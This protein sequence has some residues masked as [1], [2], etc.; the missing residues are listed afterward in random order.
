MW[1]GVLLA[2]AQVSLTQSAYSQETPPT[3]RPDVVDTGIKPDAFY[4]LDEFGNRV[5]LPGLTFEEIDRL[6]KS[7]SGYA[8]N[9]TPY[10][11]EGISITGSARE[12]EAELA[13]TVKIN[14]A[15][16]PGEYVAIP[17]SMSTFHLRGP[18]DVT[19]VEE[20][21]MKWLEEGGSLLWVRAD[22]PRKVEVIMRVVTRVGNDSGAGIEFRLPLAPTNIS[23]NV[24]GEGL[25]ANV[26]GRGDEIVRTSSGEP[27]NT[28]VEIEC[29]GG[30]FSLQWQKRDTALP[31]DQVLE[32]N[33]RHRVLWEDPQAPPAIAVE[34]EVQNRR[35]NIGPFEISL[36]MGAEILEPLQNNVSVQLAT[37]DAG[38]G[39]IL[40]TPNAAE[41][42][43]RVKFLIEY[44]LPAG[45]YTSD[46]P[47]KVLPI[48]VSNA[49]RHSGEVDVRINRNFR[50]R[51]LQS[52]SV[53]SAWR[54][55]TADP[56][57]QRVYL[58]QFDRV[59]FELPLWLIAKQ[60]RLRIEPEYTFR[61]DKQ[62]VVLEAMISATGTA[63][64]G[65]PLLLDAP[66]WNISS[67]VDQVSGLRLD[68]ALSEDGQG[69]EL[70]LAELA[71]NANSTV[72]VRWNATL[73]EPAE[74]QQVQF[75]IPQIRSV[76]DRSILVVPAIL[77]L[78]ADDDLS[79]IADLEKST[80]L[81]PQ[82]ADPSSLNNS[83]LN[84][85][86]RVQ[87]F[88]LQPTDGLPV[89]EGY[90]V[91]KPVEASIEATVSA[92]LIADD[93]QVVQD[94]S[95]VPSGNLKGQL[96]LRN[97]V[98]AFSLQHNGVT[99]SVPVIWQIYVNDQL[100]LLRW[101]GED[102]A[103]LYADM[104]ASL[105]CRIRMVATLS[106]PKA[107][108]SEFENPEELIVDVRTPRSDLPGVRVVG[109]VPLS[110]SSST[111]FD[112]SLVLDGGTS[113][114]S[115]DA[116]AFD[117]S[118]IRIHQRQQD[119][120]SRLVVERALLRSEIGRSR[121]YDRLLCRVVGG[122]NNFFV[123][124]HD[125]VFK[126]GV[127]DL[128]VRVYIDGVEANSFTI[129]NTRLSI[130]LSEA[131][132]SRLVDIRMWQSRQGG[133]IADFIEPAMQLPI[134]TGKTF[135]DVVLPTDRHLIW[136]SSG[137]NELMLWRYS[138]LFVQ[139]VA[140]RTHAELLEWI[141]GPPPP[142]SQGGNRYL[143]VSSDPSSLMFMEAGKPILWLLVSSIVLTIST[144]L[145][146]VPR[147]RHPL[148]A[149]AAATLVAGMAW[150]V[151]DV[152][153]IS[154][155]LFIGAFIVVAVMFG[156]RA[157]LVRRP[158]ATVM[159]GTGEISSVHSGTGRRNLSPAEPTSTRLHEAVTGSSA[160]GAPP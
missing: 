104:L 83:T 54:A 160:V 56:L 87:K 93:L 113:S 78:T 153:V 117:S 121:R 155:Q 106:L 13:V 29:T 89:F 1:L 85:G 101:T 97:V 27:G 90:L 49:V 102:H 107:A 139:R 154:G 130:P 40:V 149:V 144:L 19:G 2:A 100:G 22:Q 47:L 105:P 50:L 51:W 159:G 35:G 123:S 138:Q 41:P 95:V 38:A 115:K 18:A 96:P 131:K 118:S 28:K 26:L 46:S 140:T 82:P 70:V 61:V 79:V 3:N 44:R 145:F 135:W 4:F 111:E 30:D 42:T 53:R 152:A 8:P 141:G 64:E 21:G 122:D 9:A 25:S 158:R 66:G 136:S 63:L 74:N 91:D 33:S 10:T 110:L 142:E 16:T 12:T 39:K 125:S 84:S 45:D 37:R 94:W 7:D 23:I 36:P 109:A 150:L 86:S 52:P 103:T 34:M 24:A 58:F 5:M 31:S 127:S 108:V 15:A 98:Q 11:F 157:I 151:P 43:G 72:I 116:Y 137:S 129:Q 81:T 134:S 133:M 156:V 120:S 128:A 88:R 75:R 92:S 73:A 69:L 143:L 60:Q 55:S 14:V 20:S 17:L 99:I 126:N 80:G 32:V 124:L 59:P 119:N 57:D 71:T 77:N 67:V 148:I 65:V 132:E 147:L 68:D 114:E 62:G 6:L 76:D 48:G 146:Y 112:V